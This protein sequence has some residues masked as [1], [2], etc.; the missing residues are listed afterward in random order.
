MRGMSTAIDVNTLGHTV[1]ASE[2]EAPLQL[3]EKAVEMVRE[4][5]TL[6]KDESGNPYAGLRVLVQGGGCSGFQY[7][8]DF[9]KA[10][11][12]GDFEMKLGGLTVFVDA[13]SAMLLE[14]TT[15][16]YVMGLSGAGFKFNNP[17]ASNTCGCGSSFN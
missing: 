10:A 6:E 5:M 8:L 15:I 16:D 11:K 14:G 2:A 9:D 3:T 7:G 17:S 12:P 13:I 4:A 1:L